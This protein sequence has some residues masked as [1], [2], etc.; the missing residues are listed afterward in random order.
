MIPTNNIK[1]KPQLKDGDNL[2]HYLEL[3]EIVGPFNVTRSIDITDIGDKFPQYVNDLVKDR[4]IV[5]INVL[6]RKR[7][8]AATMNGHN[9]ILDGYAPF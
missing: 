7:S 3:E 8:N 2:I 4:E 6:F 9:E 5:N 1:W